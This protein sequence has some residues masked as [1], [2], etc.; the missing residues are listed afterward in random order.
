MRSPPRKVSTSGDSPRGLFAGDDIEMTLPHLQVS[1]FEVT[2]EA[3]RVHERGALEPLTQL[4]SQVRQALAVL[5][6]ST[7]DPHVVFLRGCDKLAQSE[8]AQDA[9][10]AARDGA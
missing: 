7:S 4:R 9:C 10:A 3:L 2:G 5:R 8:L 6:Q 1:G